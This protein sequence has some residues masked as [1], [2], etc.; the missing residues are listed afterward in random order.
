[1]QPPR[2]G[3]DEILASKRGRQADVVGFG[4]GVGVTANASQ[5]D[6]VVSHRDRSTDQALGLAV[7]LMTSAYEIQV[8]RSV[9]LDQARLA[10]RGQASLPTK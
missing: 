4:L 9:S 6:C 10:Q 3:R 1:M 8:N 2:H 7:Q 5:S